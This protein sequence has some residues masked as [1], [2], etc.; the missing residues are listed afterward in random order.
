M[1]IVD[2]DELLYVI[3]GIAFIAIIVYMMRLKP[4]NSP[5]D[6]DENV[7]IHQQ[8]EWSLPI[9]SYNHWHHWINT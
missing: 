1:S 3:Y 9:T 4:Y 7:H 5:L 8:R 6:L 2:M